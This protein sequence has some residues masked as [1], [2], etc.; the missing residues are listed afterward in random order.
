MEHIK[1]AQLVILIVIVMLVS[2]ITTGIVTASLLN[3]SSNSI[4]SSLKRLTSGLTQGVNQVSGQTG[5]TNEEDMRVSAVK[6]VSPS[7]VS[8]IATKD[9]PVFEQYYTTPNQGTSPN[10]F[11]G[12]FFQQ[13]NAPQYQQKGTAPQQIGSGSGF[14]ATANGYIVTNRH[15][16]EDV[17]AKYTVIMNDGSKHDAT[18][19]ARDPIQD[20]AILKIDGS[21][22]PIVTLGNSDD[23]NIGQTAIAIGNALGEFQN[24]VSVG[25]ISGLGRNITA[26]GGDSAPE[27]LRKV[28]QTDAAINPGNSGG[29]L[30]N[31]RG[32]VVGINTAMAGNA[33]NIG[34]ALPI[35]LVKKDLLSVTKSGKISYPF[36]GIHYVIVTP[37][38]KDEKKLSVDYGALLVDGQDGTPAVVSGSPSEKAGLKAGDIVLEIN[39]SKIDV[40]HPLADEIEKHNVGDA[41]H[42]KVLRDGSQFDK[43][44]IL[45]ERTQ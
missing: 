2:S 14:I 38:V 13:F 34:F 15:V 26:G 18:V 8:V 41:I 4:S 45:T 19:V 37:T 5:I 27:E 9:L 40:N 3:P 43:D 25:V 21:N 17:S 30:L 42:I 23:I 39:G 24:T 16:V 20:L 29:P 36:F 11:F 10:D 7:V 12:Q 28:I 35:N 33:E 44:V 1:K 22:L 32:E 6:R 31:S